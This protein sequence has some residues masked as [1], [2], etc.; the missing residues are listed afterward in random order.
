M[1]DRRNAVVHDLHRTSGTFGSVEPHTLAQALGIDD[2]DRPG[3]DWSFTRYTR[4]TTAEEFAKYNSPSSELLYWLEDFV[5]P[6][7]YEELL[8]YVDGV[9]SAN[10]P[11]FSFLSP[12]ER[13]HIEN[14][15]AEEQYDEDESNG[16]QCIAHRSVSGTGGEKL[17][18]EA[19]IED[20]GG[21]ITL[22]TPYDKRAEK[23]VDLTNC[24]VDQW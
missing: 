12:E 11:S 9:D 10:H 17:E 23:F 15:I 6:E 4:R 1:D 21:C 7:R 3:G 19:E 8:K 20:D 5:D 14:N 24:R 22:R 16:M 2:T 13:G 18:F